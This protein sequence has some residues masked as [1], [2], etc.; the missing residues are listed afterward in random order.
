MFLLPLIIFYEVASLFIDPGGMAAARDR[1]IAFRLLQIFF[2]LFGVTGVLLPGFA[3][4]A[5]LLATHVASRQ[6][7]RVNTHGVA[8]MYIESLLWALPLVALNQFTNIAAAD[9][10]AQTWVANVAL[11]V[12]AG[13]YEELVF[14][15]ALIGLIVIVGVDILRFPQSSTLIA[16][17][18]IAA[19][20]FALHHHP[21]FGGEPFDVFRFTFRSLAGVYLGAI[22]V[23]RG[24]GPAAGAH[25][26][27][28][29]LVIAMVP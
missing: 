12:G 3:V 18:L 21:P 27:Y 5:I 25:I 6:R 9:A 22:F 16:A 28:N 14:R 4:I 17:V 1:V 7:W 2:E 15:L 26:G 10:P 13:I 19:G 8:F 23:V 24:Y 29:L 11:C 20:L